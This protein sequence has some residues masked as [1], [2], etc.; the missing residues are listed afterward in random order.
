METMFHQKSKKQI[1]KQRIQEASLKFFEQNK[2]AVMLLLQHIGFS[3]TIPEFAHKPIN[4]QE[5]FSIL[6]NGKIMQ[7]MQY[8]LVC[9]CIW[10]K[11]Q[12]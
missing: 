4:F 8:L 1:M 11:L 3:K 12:I 5:L 10:F 9:L 6:V 2:S 7:M